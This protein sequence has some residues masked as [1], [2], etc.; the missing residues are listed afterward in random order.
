MRGREGGREGG[1]KEGWG[2]EGGA[3]GKR[4]RAITK[5]FVTLQAEAAIILG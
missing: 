3:V 2:E 5:L 1:G 4:S